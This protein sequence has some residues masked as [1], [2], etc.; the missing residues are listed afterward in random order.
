MRN[1]K[2]YSAFVTAMCVLLSIMLLACACGTEQTENKA[3]T[4]AT[5]ASATEAKTTA[6]TT[7]DEPIITRPAKT[8]EAVPTKVT[9]TVKVVG[10]D[11]EAVQGVLI[12]I[13]DDSGCKM[14]DTTNA[15]GIVTFTYPESNFHA[16]IQPN[17]IPAGYTATTDQYDFP[18]GETT[19]T[20]TL[21]KAN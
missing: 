13:C 19:I 21:A 3:T 18:A 11:G 8:T 5:K 10:P 14:P 6:A 16:Q 17:G 9:Y 20:I 12:G 2:K 7:T 1:L 4:E 15:D